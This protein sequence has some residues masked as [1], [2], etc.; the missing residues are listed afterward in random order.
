VRTFGC[1]NMPATIVLNPRQIIH[2]Q[3]TI[4]TGI[5]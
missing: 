1:V 2:L 3:L 5:R 4:D